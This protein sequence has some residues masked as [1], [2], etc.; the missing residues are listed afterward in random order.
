ML[1][2][3]VYDAVEVRAKLVDLLNADGTDRRV[4]A[5]RVLFAKV[6]N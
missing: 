1:I 3:N 2:V 6:L 4:N 5:A